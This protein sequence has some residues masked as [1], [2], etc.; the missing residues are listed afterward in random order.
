MHKTHLFP[1]LWLIALLLSLSASVYAQLTDVTQPG[2]PI[3][4]RISPDALAHMTA[5][6]L[7]AR[8]HELGLD[9]PVWLRYLRWL[10][11]LKI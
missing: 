1:R 6:D 4:A 5:A 7:D 2:D 8:R 9:G 3:V 10:A 11:G